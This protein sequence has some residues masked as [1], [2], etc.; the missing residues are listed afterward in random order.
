MNGQNRDDIQAGMLVAVVLIKDQGTSILTRG[1]VR[2][3]LTKSQSHPH[4]I[5]VM[6]W[7]EISLA[8]LK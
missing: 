7:G 5:K 3:V 4:G 2:R 8:G 1:R 6:P